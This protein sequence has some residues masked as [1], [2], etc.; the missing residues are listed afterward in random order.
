MFFFVFFWWRHAQTL[1]PGAAEAYEHDP[2]PSS[3]ASDN[4]PPGLKNTPVPPPKNMVRATTYTIVYM[5]CICEL[6]QCI[7][8]VK[9]A[10]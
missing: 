3:S 5:Q 9:H 2:A 1:L 6:R 7:C 10:S 4:L 8:E